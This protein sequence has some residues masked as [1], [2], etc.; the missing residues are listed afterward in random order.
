MSDEMFEKFLYYPDRLPPDAI[1]PT[2]TPPGAEEVWLTCEDGVRIHGLWWGE[3]AGRP[4]I[5]FLHGNAQD[6]YSWSLVREDLEAAACRLLLIDYRGYGKSEGEPSESG[7]YLD[8]RASLSWL[9]GQGIPAGDTVIFGKSL[10]GGVACE[11][12][13]DR[14][15]AGLVLESTFTSLASV[16]G[17]LFP[18]APGMKPGAHAYDSVNKLKEISC[19]LLVIHGERDMLIPVAEGLALYQAAGEPRELFIVR[20]AGHNEVS[21]VAGEAYGRT[22]RDWLDGEPAAGGL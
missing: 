5:L 3:P 8:G 12:A 10:G 13:R 4:A 9:Q 6:V 16:A 2:W 7:L 18:F 21:I 15:L 1:P 19:P 11:I 17:N 22:L 20:G 14:V